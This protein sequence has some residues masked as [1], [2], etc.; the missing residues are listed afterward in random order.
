MLNFFV[1]GFAAVAVFGSLVSCRTTSGAGSDMKRQPGGSPSNSEQPS[2]QSGNVLEVRDPQATMIYNAFPENLKSSGASSYTGRLSFACSMQAREL[3]RGAQGFPPPP[4]YQCSA[5]V[6][7]PR[8]ASGIPGKS[9][10][11]FDG[12]AAR[13]AYKALKV[14]PENL[15]RGFSLKSFESENAIFACLSKTPSIPEGAQGF[16]MAMRVCTITPIDDSSPRPVGLPMPGTGGAPRPVGL[17]MPGTG[18]TPTPVGL[19][20]PGTGQG[21]QD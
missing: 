6:P 16:V 1:V 18:E 21:Y 17:P 13:E 15:G 10:V 14:E 20:M 12:E 3:P 7:L 4:A 2:A 19:P 8:G 11:T 5:G 9:F